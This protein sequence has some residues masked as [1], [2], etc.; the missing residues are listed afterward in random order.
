MNASF[1]FSLLAVG[2][3][4]ATGCAVNSAPDG[5]RQANNGDDTVFSR[6]IVR[7]N[8][9]GTKTSDVS[10]VTKRAQVDHRE[11][12]KTDPGRAV[13]ETPDLGS[14]AATSASTESTDAVHLPVQT[15]MTECPGLEIWDGEG[16]TGD[17]VC[18]TSDVA[19]P[20]EVDLAQ[21]QRYVDCGE[22]FCY[23]GTWAFAVKSFRNGPQGVALSGGKTDAAKPIVYAPQ[24]SVLV[25][26]PRLQQTGF[27]TFIPTSTPDSK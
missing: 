15:A 23:R 1:R 26:D 11:L 5:E 13:P 8:P 20:S 25:A 19:I 17:S 3:A 6:T 4:L 2:L 7:I 12:G 10:F 21:V 22:S 16:N 14:A 24:S 27:V 9:D 18:F